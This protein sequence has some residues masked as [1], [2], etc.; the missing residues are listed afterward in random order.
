MNTKRCVHCGKLSRADAE[1]CTR[2]RHNFSHIS[3]PPASPHRAG[4]YSGLHPEDQPYQSSFMP[5]L[6]P[7]TPVILSPSPP[8]ISPSPRQDSNPP[9]KDSSLRERAPT[10]A[11]PVPHT[12]FPNATW[13]PKS[14][15]QGTDRLLPVPQTGSHSDWIDDIEEE[16]PDEFILPTV[17]LPAS[18][19]PKAVWVPKPVRK[20]SG[21]QRSVYRNRRS[22]T[23]RQSIPPLRPLMP[24]DPDPQVL[25]IEHFKVFPS[26]VPHQ[27]RMWERAVPILLTIFCLLFLVAT[28]LLAFLFLR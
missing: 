19:N 10:P 1:Y 15:R 26:H 11:F 2:C 21:A 24:S 4:H 22:A 20:T 8:H 28:S 5:A 12:G 6:H 9:D 16:E 18:S 23:Q 27:P 25:P 3:T 17:L 7:P 14:E 13:V